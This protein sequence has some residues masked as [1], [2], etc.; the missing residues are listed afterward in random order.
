MHMKENALLKNEM[1]EKLLMLEQ[2]GPSLSQ[3]KM[4]LAKNLGLMAGE[5][6][7]KSTIKDWMHESEEEVKKKE[8]H[9]KVQVEK[10]KAH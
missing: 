3:P 7:R 9:A 5:D 1:K 2:M 10:W 8:E 6:V 4:I